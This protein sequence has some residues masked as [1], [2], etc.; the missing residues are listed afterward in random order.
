ML[1]PGE[2]RKQIE[3]DEFEER[4]QDLKNMI[5]DQ[6]PKDLSKR[7]EGE[8]DLQKQILQELQKV[9]ENMDKLI[10]SNECLISAVSKLER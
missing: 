5:E 7:L 3:L 2:E 8:E 9:N 10:F 1:N 6:I 4:E